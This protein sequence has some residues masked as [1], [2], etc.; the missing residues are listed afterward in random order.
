MKGLFVPSLTLALTLGI[1][2]FPTDSHAFLKKLF[3]K[4]PTTELKE[5][6]KLEIEQ[7]ATEQLVDAERVAETE[8]EKAAIK[9]FEKIIKDYPLTEAAADAQF[10]IGSLHKQAGNLEDAFEAHQKLITKYRQSPRFAEAVKE[11]FQIAEGAKAGN[12]VTFV[13]IPMKLTS[14]RIIE[15]YETVISNAP[16][17]KDAPKA[18]FSIAEIQQDLGRRPAAVAAYQRVV[19]DY[20]NSP[21]AKDAQFRIGQISNLVSL[22]SEDVGSIREAQAAMQT[23]VLENP[24][25][26]E[27]PD[28][29]AILSNLKKR[30]LGK[31]MEI[32]RFYEKTGKLKAAKIYYQGIANFPDSEFYAEATERLDFL[33]E[34][35]GESNSETAP[36]T[37][38]EKTPEKS[39]SKLASTFLN[40]FNKSDEALSDEEPSE[41]SQSKFVSTF[42]NIFNKSAEEPSD[43]GP[44]DEELS[45]EKPS[46]KSQSKLTSRFLSI[47]KKTPKEPS[48]KSQSNLTS[49]LLGSFKETP[50]E[51]AEKSQSKFATVHHKDGSKTLLIKA[52]PRYVGPRAPDLDHLL[53]KPKPRLSPPVNVIGQNDLPAAL[54]KQ[55]MPGETGNLLLPPPPSGGES[56]PSAP[57]VPPTP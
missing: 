1:F 35:T 12:K 55:D 39:Q 11:Q 7:A 13:G 49:R 36:A 3:K 22:K 6:E 43:E 27:S 5:E 31:D 53:K 29:R 32:A 16:F 56:V 4:P 8:K 47:F 15:M 24:D 25:A 26:E 18:M 46:E 38:P 17:G 40:I 33:R 57:I 2:A 34:A 51:P 52:N 20:P 42:H 48:E 50:K 37:L 41:K 28:A 19:D 10:Q 30:D 54:P 21:E 23:F 45:N 14:S 44:S 9:A